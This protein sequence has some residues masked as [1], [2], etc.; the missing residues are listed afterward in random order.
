MPQYIVTVTDELGNT[1][2]VETEGRLFCWGQRRKPA[3]TRRISE[4]LR[5]EAAACVGI[6]SR[7]S[8][9]ARGYSKFGLADKE[10]SFGIQDASARAASLES[11]AARI[12]GTEADAL[13]AVA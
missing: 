8:E 3:P 12:E 11:L 10:A 2:D 13:I 7:A 4:L 5:D 1:Y 6:A 9:R